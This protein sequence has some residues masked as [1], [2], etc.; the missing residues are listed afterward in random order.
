MNW[1]EQIAPTI[2][3]AVAGPLGGLA[4]EAVSRALNIS[5]DDAKSV[6]ESGKLTGDQVAALK[7]AEID[8][9]KQQESLGLDF[10]K[11]AADDRKSARDMQ[12]QT[13]SITPSLLTWIVVVAVLVLEGSMLYGVKITV[14]DIVL[15]R[16]L[17]TLD[18]S[19]GLVLAFWFGSNSASARKTELLAQSSPAK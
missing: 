7:L 13:H 4:Y 19:L 18:T 10:E 6:L 9:K 8:L 2:A 12:A 5:T 14:S 16:I 1:L 11:L 17:G 3:N 15:G